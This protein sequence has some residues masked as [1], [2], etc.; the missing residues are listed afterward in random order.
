MQHVVTSFD[1]LQKLDETETN[2]Y[3]TLSGGAKRPDRRERDEFF[4]GEAY[5]KARHD[6]ETS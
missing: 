5:G 3:A 1:V 2:E 4:P 6:P